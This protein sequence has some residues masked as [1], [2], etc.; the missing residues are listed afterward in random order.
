[1]HM[2]SVPNSFGR[3]E[4]QGELGRGGMARVFQGYDPRFKR[5][6]AI[7]VLSDTF[8]TDSTFQERFEREAQTIASL[9]HSAIVPVYDY[10]KEGDVPYLVMRYMEGG[11]LADRIR[12]EQLSNDDI[13]KIIRRIGQALDA[14]HKQGIIHRDI[15]PGNILFDQYGDAY[16]SDF[17]IVKLAQAT[18]SL[19]GGGVVGTPSYMAPEMGE[20]DKISKLID[21]Y[22]LGVTLYEMFSRQ[23]P[24]QS[25][26]PMAVLMMHLSQPVPDIRI[27]RPDLPTPV[28]AVIEKAMSKDPA[29]RFQSGVELAKTLEKAISSTDMQ[30]LPA[31]QLDPLPLPH[32][33]PQPLQAFI[34]PPP[35]SSAPP[36]GS[37]PQPPQQP[38]SSHLIERGQP[39]RF[40]SSGC[41]IGGIAAVVLVAL[42][43]LGAVL[44]LGPTLFTTGDDQQAGV[45]SSEQ[46]ATPTEAEEPTG[47][48]TKEPTLTPTP[49]PSISNIRFCDRPCNEPGARQTFTFP[50]DT[51]VVYITWE[52]EGFQEGT[53][54]SRQWTSRNEVFVRYECVWRGLESGEFDLRLF[55]LNNGLRS[56][57][58]ELTITAENE[59]IVNEAFTVTG[60]NDGWDPVGFAEA[61]PDF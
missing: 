11:S 10:G 24:F 14:A 13:L 58:W 53:R 12:E 44:L 52:Y 36:P 16:L 55:D 19:T 18:S 42:L 51:D 35:A 30:H 32:Q 28:Q 46:T 8:S 33:Q 26:T 21:I 29:T 23:P 34:P 41:I 61:C 39:Q 2:G 37:S 49:A 4:I 25:D 47:T 5:S 6:V 50:E 3:Y 17:G 20:P 54:Y 43:G 7:K 45:G 27:V 40:G 60:S 48:P 57:Q 59:E 56:G 15:K 1:M 22:A 31:T 9:E 38:P